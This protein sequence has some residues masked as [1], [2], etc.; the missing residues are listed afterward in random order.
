MRHLGFYVNSLHGDS[1][2]VLALGAGSNLLLMVSWHAQY[3]LG[4]QYFKITQHTASDKMHNLGTWGCFL[5]EKRHT[6]H[7][8]M[9]G[10]QCSP[11]GTEGAETWLPVENHEACL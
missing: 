7:T 10:A 3:V 5:G 9:I 4:G 6:R 2:H 8:A 11:I 1:A